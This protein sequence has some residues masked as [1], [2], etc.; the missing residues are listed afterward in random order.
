MFKGVQ[1][2]SG[3]GCGRPWPIHF[4]PANLGQSIFGQSIC[5]LLCCCCVVL[6]F[7]CVVWLCCV[8]VWLCG[9]LGVGGL[10]GV[11][12]CRCGYFGPSG[13]SLRQTAQNGAFFPPAP[14]F[15]LFVSLWV[16]SRGILVVFLKG[17]SNVHGWV[18]RLS[19]ETPAASWPPGL[20]M[21]ARELLS[22]TFKGSTTAFQT[23]PKFHE[24]TPRDLQ[25]EQK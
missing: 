9:V 23:P 25:K 19:C 3:V 2:C 4:W 14:I 21:T 5:V 10:F 15:A 7:G 22:R 8:V 17:P 16:S 6:L 13:S 12:R 11:V 18:L 24:K 1:Q 20:H